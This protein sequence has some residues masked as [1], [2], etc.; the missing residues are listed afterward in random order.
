MKAG[1]TRTM[2]GTAL[3]PNGGEAI[4]L[5]AENGETA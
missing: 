2:L 1:W 4:I 3:K 5:N